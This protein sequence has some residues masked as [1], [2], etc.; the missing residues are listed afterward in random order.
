MSQLTIELPRHASLIDRAYLIAK[1]ATTP[2]TGG[3]ILTDL[4]N[5]LQTTPQKLWPEILTDDRFIKPDETR[6]VIRINL[7]IEVRA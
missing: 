1:A 6:S 4:C 2:H 7:L 5:M 3:V